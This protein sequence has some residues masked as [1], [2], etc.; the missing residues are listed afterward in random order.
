MVSKSRS[1]TSSNG[2]YYTPQNLANFF[3]EHIITDAKS[4]IFDPAYGHG[5]LLHAAEYV[6]QRK[7]SKQVKHQLFGCDI[8]P[9]NGNLKHLHKKIYTKKTF[10]TSLLMIN[11]ML[12]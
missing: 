5:S 7:K 6:L 2:V 9:L 3:A 1:Q 10:S 8:A 11:L 12:F 4:T